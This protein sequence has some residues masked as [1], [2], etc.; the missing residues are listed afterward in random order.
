M[1]TYIVV[2]SNVES[3]SL[4]RRKG[5]EDAGEASYGAKAR[6]DH[7]VRG[8][9]GEAEVVCVPTEKYVLYEPSLYA[10]SERRVPQ[11]RPLLGATPIVQRHGRMVRAA[12]GRSPSHRRSRPRP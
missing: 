7:G 12:N 1:E 10:S 5:Q 2:G 9:R 6:G 4:E 3:R 8:D 11:G